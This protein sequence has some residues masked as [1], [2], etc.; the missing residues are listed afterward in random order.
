V[1]TA[2]NATHISPF[3]FIACSPNPISYLKENSLLAKASRE[4][5]FARKK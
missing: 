1:A 4:R 3:H 2:A 5:C